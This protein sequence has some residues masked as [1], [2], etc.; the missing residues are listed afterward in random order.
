LTL[1]AVM[2]DTNIVSA[3]MRNPRGPIFE[4]IERLGGDAVCMSIISAAELQFGFERRGSKRLVVQ[5]ENLKATIS[6]MPFDAP[7]HEVYGA[8]RAELERRGTPIGPN[9]L[10]IAA[11]ALALDLTL[12]T[13]NVSEFSRV[14]GLRVENWLD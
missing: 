11:H 1:L 3:V 7:A 14:P 6:M 8:I 5:L 4:R 10:F 12:I 2:L 9:D 13:A